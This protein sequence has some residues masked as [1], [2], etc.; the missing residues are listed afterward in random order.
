MAFCTECGAGL[1]EKALFC[2]NCGATLKKTE[3]I[4]ND[5]GP[6][7]PSQN[8]ENKPTSAYGQPDSF[9]HINNEGSGSYEADRSKLQGGFAFEPETFN[10][11]ELGYPPAAYKGKRRKSLNGTSVLIIIIASAFLLI[12]LASVLIFKAL[13][14]NN[15]KKPNEDYDT[16]SLISPPAGTGL[17]GSGKLSKGIYYV[18]IIGAQAAYDSADT[19]VMRVYYEFTN[20]FSYSISA[21]EALGFSASQDGYE[22]NPAY[23]WGE[24][25]VFSNHYHY[26]RPGISI[27][28]C[29]EFEYDEDGGTVDFSI[30]SWKDGAEAGKVTASY[31]PK[32][33]P[34]APAVYVIKPV[35]DPVWTLSIDSEGP[36]DGLYYVSVLNAELLDDAEGNPAIRVYYDFKNNSQDDISLYNALYIL[37]YQDGI[38]LSETYLL[39]SSKTDNDIHTEIAP[40]ETIR[41]SAV[42]KLRNETSAVEANVEAYTSYAAVGQTY[43][44]R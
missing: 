22:L 24:D 41:A 9:I 17:D 10:R 4:Q 30:F 42:F 16:P 13:N 43:K 26:I 20:N 15:S 14:K 18:S 32:N 44:I 7:F 27:Q 5:E 33:L 19:P 40:G 36:L 35:P 2:P 3:T 29:Y 31:D 1:P 11:E 23:T 12:S 6:A 37:S 28:C 39:N 38:S 25:D 8:E 34:G 21:W